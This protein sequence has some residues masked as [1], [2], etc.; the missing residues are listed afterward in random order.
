MN[1]VM[2]EYFISQCRE[3]IDKLNLI[4]NGDFTIEKVGAGRYLIEPRNETSSGYL[5]IEED[6]IDN[7]I[8]LLE[9]VKKILG[10]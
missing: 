2:N 9:C 6:E 4:G 10:K 3:E 5:Y 7:F 1:I 8:K